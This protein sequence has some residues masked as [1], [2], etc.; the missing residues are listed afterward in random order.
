MSIIPDDGPVIVGAG[1]L[2]T[3]EQVA[4]ILSLGASGVVLGTR[5]CL[6]PE[7][8]YPDHY[9]QA[10]IA[11]GSTAS[12]RSAAFDQVGNWLEWPSG[13]GGRGLRNSECGR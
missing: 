5:F 11:A 6:T 13:V 2:A 12:V 4:E 10:L 9:K 1:G 8:T 7:S 3:G